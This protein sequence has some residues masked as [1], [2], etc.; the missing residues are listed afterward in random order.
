[1]PRLR[2][3]GLATALIV[4][5]LALA[6]RFALV[7]RTRAGFP[8][9][10]PPRF[11]PADL[12]LPFESLTIPS[13]SGSLPAWFIPANG[14]RAGPGVV[15]VHGWES[16]RD[17]AL[18]YAQFLH[19]AGL[20][21]LLFDVRGHGANEAETLPIS[22][23]EFGADAAAAI[24]VMLARP[25]VTTVAVMGHSMGGT[26]AI[27]AA[28]GNPRIAALVSTSAPSDAHRL[29]RQTFRLAR[30]P[31]PDP[32]A[33]PLAW[34]T[35]RIYL[36]PRRHRIEAVSA[37]DMIGGYAGPILLIH[38]RN[39]AVVPLSHLTRLAAAAGNA[40]RSSGFAPLE[41][42]IVPEGRHSWLHE[43]ETYRRTVAR[44]LAEWLGGPYS[45]ADAA[46]RA[47][48]VDAQRL[49]EQ[50]DRFTAVTEA[51]GRLRTMAELSG[52]VPL[53]AA[54]PAPAGAGDP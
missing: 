24:E 26:G 6:Y 48:A 49:P 18:P 27:I 51:P 37:R 29:T 4:A 33:Y 44:F 52:A 43:D 28:A 8:R 17:R 34:L 40:R 42:L 38:G 3:A 21:C 5:P 2:R 39:D 25:E 31:F 14:G 12:G 47:A 1:M 30:L 53:A 46:D 13:P 41:V 22:G 50:D 7:Y 20:H 36:K 16:A 19:A 15:L 10:R 32:I 23:G 9:Q 35:A 54:D 45:P 11:T